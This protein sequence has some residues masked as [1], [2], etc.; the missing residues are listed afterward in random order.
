MLISDDGSDDDDDEDLGS[1][2]PLTRA[3][4]SPQPPEFKWMTT[5]ELK[6]NCHAERFMAM[7]NTVRALDL[8]QNFRD[9]YREEER[10][11]LQ[12]SPQYCYY[13]SLR[14][15]DQRKGVTSA[16]VDYLRGRWDFRMKQPKRQY[17]Q[18][19]LQIPPTHGNLRIVW[20]PV[21]RAKV[22]VH[23]LTCFRYNKLPDQTK[24]NWK[25]FQ[26]SERCTNKLCFRHEHLCWESAADNQSRGHS[27]V[28]CQRGCTHVGCVTGFVCCRCNNIHQPTCVD[29]TRQ[30]S[31][32][33]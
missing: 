22:S 26:C 30:D 31:L 21:D 23:W 1:T 4:T 15:Q 12:T 10:N 11:K 17:L 7:Y 32:L 18:K 19:F 16:V 5:D 25:T 2:P 27:K 29:G 33:P 14:D 24:A 6:E 3:S 20:I 9:L 28:W 13:T 8:S